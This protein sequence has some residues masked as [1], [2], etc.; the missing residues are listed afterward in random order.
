MLKISSSFSKNH[1]KKVIL[2]LDEIFLRENLSVNSRTLTYHG[3]EDFGDCFE[4]KM[5]EKANNTLVH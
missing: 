4:N 2:V 3:L 5:T 1:Q